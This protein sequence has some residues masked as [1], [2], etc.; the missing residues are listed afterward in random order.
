MDEPIRRP[1]TFPFCGRLIA[2][3]TSRSLQVGQSFDLLD[4]VSIDFP[5]MPDTVE[6]V[7]RADYLV[8][9]NINLPDGIHLYKG[10]NPLEIPL[11]FKL[12]SFDQEYC[13]EGALTLLQ[14][15]SRLHSFVLPI[16]TN[17]KA[18]ITAR[19]GEDTDPPNNDSSVADR[20][21][22]PNNLV[23]ITVAG[24]D[25]FPPVT[26]ILELLYTSADQ[27]GISCVG[28]VK[29]VRTALNGPW[30][31]GPGKSYNLPS[32]ADFAF[33]F[34]HRPGHGN[35]FK[36]VAN[37]P[38]RAVGDLQPQ[39]FANW[40]KDHLYN[41]RALV[42]VANYRGFAAAP[43]ATGT[44]DN[45]NAA[46]RSQAPAT[47][48]QFRALSQAEQEDAAIGAFLRKSGINYVSPS[49]QQIINSILG[50]PN[51]G[52]RINQRQ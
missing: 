31:R 26:C 47:S 32:S 13:P 27:P 36:S 43:E 4:A 8:Q 16:S 22:T 40:V 19:A 50:N 17:D 10:T 9:S 33:T 2:L 46:T 5:A 18:T 3:P 15:V 24:A 6:L 20:A 11:S 37:S 39:A 30:L 35:D 14:L 12:H 51:T 28:Y 48:G 7:R 45:G 1:T 49:D 25:V 21:A 44:P 34:V 29:D 38:T 52:Q 41:T 23:A 42:Q